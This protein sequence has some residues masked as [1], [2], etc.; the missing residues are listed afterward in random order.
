MDSLKKDPG[1]GG[2]EARAPEGDQIKAEFAKRWTRQCF[3][4]GQ[5]L[6]FMF[7]TIIL[8]EQGYDLPTPFYVLAVASV[9]LGLA[10]S[11]WNW[12]CPHC[13]TYF[14]KKFFGLKFCQS[15]GAELAS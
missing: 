15:C 11:F 5:I 7:P 14:G 1:S 3:I 2:Q 9:L 8:S 4:S 6:L 12:R 13:S 10:G